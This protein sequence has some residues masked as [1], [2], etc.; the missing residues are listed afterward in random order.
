[1]GGDHHEPASGPDVPRNPETRH[2]GPGGDARFHPHAQPRRI[3][4]RR[5]RRR[6]CRSDL[7]DL[8]ADRAPGDHA[9]HGR[10]VSPFRLER[11]FVLAQPALGPR[12]SRTALSHHP[13]HPLQP[14]LRHRRQGP[15]EAKIHKII[16]PEEVFAKTGYSRPHTIH[17]G[18]EGI[19]VSTLGGGGPDGTDGPPGI[20]IMDCETFEIIGR[21]EIDRGKP[22]QALRFLVE[23]AARLH[24][25]L[26]MGPAAAI[27]ERHRAGGSALQ[28]V[29]PFDPF[30]EPAR[31][32][33]RADHRSRRKPPDGAGNPARARPG[34][35]ITAFA[36]WWWTP[37]IS[38]ARSGHGGARR[39]A[40]STRKR[41]SPS[42]RAPP[43]PTTC[44][45]C[46][47]G[48]RRCRRWSPIST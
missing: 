2:G 31:A 23:P 1:M 15:R 8:R 44:R 18:P 3:A 7:E 40:A 21:Y 43:R 46:S 13:R 16:E 19:Y 30:L 29:R 14:H 42:R 24:G 27:R 37:P 4:P 35:R 22:G 20:F 36:G 33:Q 28:Q 32:A 25:E 47:R 38:R 9:Q 45:R 17:C 41:P 11:L 34:R 10:R 6:R 12:L 26:G 48:S 5:P 39:T